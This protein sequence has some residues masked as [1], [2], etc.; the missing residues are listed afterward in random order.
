MIG[1]RVGTL[2]SKSEGKLWDIDI[3]NLTVS[4]SHH[5]ACILSSY[6]PHPSWGHRHFTRVSSV[7]SPFRRPFFSPLGFRTAPRQSSGCGRRVEYSSTRS[8][9]A[10]RPRCRESSY[11]TEW[12]HRGWKSIRRVSMK[13]LTHNPGSVIFKF[14]V[15]YRVTIQVVSN[16]PLTPKQRL[17]FRTWASY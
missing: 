6:L 11:R 12:I 17:P 3:K 9:N 13:F 7:Q 2:I 14:Q 15:F 4:H 1:T 10:P 16:L 5:I 8:C